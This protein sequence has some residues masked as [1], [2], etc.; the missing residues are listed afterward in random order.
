MR[1]FSRLDISAT[2]IRG[3]ED[4]NAEQ[5]EPPLLKRQVFVLGSAL[6]LLVSDF[7]HPV[8]SLTI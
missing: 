1:A 2:Q 3:S 6:T 5:D 7:F 8:D 4:I